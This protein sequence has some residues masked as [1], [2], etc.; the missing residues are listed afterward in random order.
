VSIAASDFN[1]DGLLDV[2]VAT[3]SATVAV[4]L[5]NGAGGFGPAAGS[6]F[7]TRGVRPAA[8][9]VGDFNGDG[10]SDVAVTQRTSGDVAILLGNGAGG[11][12]T[13]PGSPVTTKGSQPT[14]A[15]V[16]DFNRD[17]R[18]DLAV[19]HVISGDVAVLLGNGT[20]GF[21]SAPGSPYTT[22]G[23]RPGAVMAGDFKRDGRLDV[24]VVNVTSGDVSVMRGNGRGRLRRAAGSPRPVGTFGPRAAVAA[25]LNKGNSP[26][27]LVASYDGGLAAMLGDGRGR[28][29]AAVGSAYNTG[30]LHPTA[31]ATGD[32][33]KDGLVDAA[34]A[35]ID[36]DNVSVLLSQG[37]VVERRCRVVQRPSTMTASG[38]ITFKLFCPFVARGTATVRAG[39]KKIGR[40]NFKVR[41]AGDA[42]RIRL[43]LSRRGRQMV[44]SAR[45]VIAGVSAR[46]YREKG[47]TRK[48]G[49]TYKDTLAIQVR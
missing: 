36:S 26:D 17:G 7:A 24:A 8:V 47:K 39:K 20:G 44:Q 41:S 14:A 9:T 43:K 48:R 31:V 49:K 34:V 21:S 12:V 45:T 38:R 3:D 22:G 23:L 35:N 5:G 10:R 27:I 29:S 16:G 6:P 42:A 28:L 11:L 33:N 30:G 15:A 13:A 2:A 18:A 46:A 32:F 19:S 37:L 25:N 4:L 40:A 1:G